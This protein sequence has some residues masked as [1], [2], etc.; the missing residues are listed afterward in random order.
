MQ[1]IWI[2]GTIGSGKTTLAKQLGE[3]YH[4]PVYHRDVISWDTEGN[5]VPE[6]EQIRVVQGITT[7]EKWI[8][9]GCRFTASKKDGRLENCDAIIFL[10]INRFICLFRALRRH[11]RQKIKATSEYGWVQIM[12]FSNIKYILWD[13]PQ[14]APEREAIFDFARKNGKS[15]FILKNKHAVKRFMDIEL[16]VQTSPGKSASRIQ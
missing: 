8:Y 16:T 9:E 4:L 11:F 13:F 5:D 6:D 3:K 12:D 15:V 7:Q 10:D 14:K 2:T 1:R